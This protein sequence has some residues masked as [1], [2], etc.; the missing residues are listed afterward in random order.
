MITSLTRLLDIAAGLLLFFVVF[1][2]VVSGVTEWIAQ[3]TGRRGAFLRLGLNRLI[4]DEAIFRRV[5]H[6]PLVGSLYRTHAA[7]GKPPSYVEPRNF[8]LALIDV[9]TTR[10]RASTAGLA[11]RQASSTTAS[12][13]SAAASVTPPVTI[14]LA[15]DQRKLSELR[16]ALDHALLAASPLGVALRPIVRNAVD[17][18]SAVAGIEQWFGAAMQRTS[19]WY[20]TRSQ[21][22]LFATGLL[23]AVGFNLDTLALYQALSTSAELRA[24]VM[25]LAGGVVG[26]DASG[27]LNLQSAGAPGLTEA[28]VKE[29]QALAARVRA[30]EISDLPLGYACWNKSSCTSAFVNAVWPF[31]RETFLRML[32]WVLT[33][34]AGTLGATYW[35]GLL[36]NVLKLRGS[37][38]KPQ[39]PTKAIGSR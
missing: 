16:D 34:L 18:Q 35:F 27:A 20:K 8:A 7:M 11:G 23:I 30:H 28:Q 22:V 1:S 2:V 39:D 17:Y 24:A 32:G 26:T 12:E 4:G 13:A 21:K 15:D 3:Y 36:V 14:V 19:G 9:V 29:A 5:L 38:A 31:S 25:P 6:H 10:L 33:A 37:G